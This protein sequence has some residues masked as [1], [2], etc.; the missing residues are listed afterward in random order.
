MEISTLK[1]KVQESVMLVEP[2]NDLPIVNTER[3]RKKAATDLVELAHEIQKADDFTKANAS[4][5]L[6]VIAEQIRFLQE[7]AKRILEDARRGNDLNHVAC[8]FKKIPG[9]L[10]YLYRRESGQK[11]FSMLSPGDWGN[12]Q[13]HEYLGTYKLE[14]DYSWTPE[15]KIAAR[16]DE[17][18]T[19]NKILDANKSLA[20]TMNT[21]MGGLSETKPSGIVEEIE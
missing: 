15:S 5:K 10:Y 7:Q 8:N 21:V 18:G 19:I 3:I 17:L 20:I 2:N 1:G 13:P 14:Y 11:Y 4:N 9:K 6:Q 16:S 12:S